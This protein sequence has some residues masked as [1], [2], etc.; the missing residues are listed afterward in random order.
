LFLIYATS[1]NASQ[2]FT[3]KAAVEGHGKERLKRKAFR[4]PWKRNTDMLRQTVPSTG[5]S[6]REGPIF[7]AVTSLPKVSSL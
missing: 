7:S 5:S 4:L 6:N 3:T 1:W 2:L